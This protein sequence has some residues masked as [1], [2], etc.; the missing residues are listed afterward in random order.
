MAEI[1]KADLPTRRRLITVLIVLALGGFLVIFAF[2]QNKTALFNWVL[3][4]PTQKAT[5]VKTMLWLACAFMESP[6]LGV[7]LFTW[8]MAE[9]VL[10]AERFPPPGIPVIRDTIVQV[11]QRARHRG[12][13]LQAVAVVFVL[14]AVITLALFWHFTFVFDHVA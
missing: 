9:R 5:R 12:R 3:A 6:L 7:A 11:G 4:D 10:V 8:K 13:L 1:Q 14:L 2:E